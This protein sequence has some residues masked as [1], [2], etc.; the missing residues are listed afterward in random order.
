MEEALSAEDAAYRVT[1]DELL[2]TWA[3]W[4]R[5]VDIRARHVQSFS[6]DGALLFTVPEMALELSISAILR[7]VIAPT[8][9]EL[10]GA[11]L[12]LAHD[13]TGLLAVHVNEGSRGSSNFNFL[14]VIRGALENPRFDHPLSYLQSIRIQDGNF[15][16]YDPD[17]KPSWEGKK[18]N[19]IIEQSKKG[20]IAEL[21]LT[22]ELDEA[23]VELGVIA[24]FV[25]KT[26]LISTDFKF[27]PLTPKQ[28]ARVT[29]TLGAL[30]GIDLPLSGR[31]TVSTDL[32]LKVHET[33]FGLKGGPGTASLHGLFPGTPSL[34]ISNLQVQGVFNP[35]LKTLALEE[36]F[37][38]TDGTIISGNG[39][40]KGE[41]SDPTLEADITVEHLPVSRIATIWPQTFAENAR[42]WITSRVSDGKLE[43][44]DAHLNFDSSAWENGITDREMI[45]AQ[46]VVKGS[47]VDYLPGLPVAESVT[48]NGWYDGIDLH[49]N[50]NEG[51]IGN[52]N[53]QNVIVNIADINGPNENGIIRVKSLGPV[54]DLVRTFGSPAVRDAGIFQIDPDML[55]GSIETA[56]AIRFPLLSDLAVNDLEV[57]GTA[58][59]ENVVARG[60][61]PSPLLPKI[62]LKNL[63]GELIIDRNGFDLSGTADTID[64]HVKYSWHENFGHVK[65]NNMRRIDVLARL[66]EA[67]RRFLKID[68]DH[69]HGFAEADITL[70]TSADGVT[71]GTIFIDVT[72]ALLDLPFLRWNKAPG[73]PGKAEISLVLKDG[74]PVSDPTFAFNSGQFLAQGHIKLNNQNSLEALVLD[75]LEVGETRLSGRLNFEKDGAQE[76]YISAEHLDLRPYNGTARITQEN[77]VVI[78]GTAEKIILTDEIS[79]AEA[80]GQL[81][82]QSD[83]EITVKGRA[84]EL[85]LR[86]YF[87]HNDDSTDLPENREPKTPSTKLTG[88]IE[89][90]L[91]DDHIHLSNLRGNAR[92]D[93]VKI[94]VADIEI[95]TENSD[96]IELRI[97]DHDKGGRVLLLASEN[98]GSVLRALDLT[99]DVVGGTLHLQGT[100]IDDEHHNPLAG[101][102]TISDFH[103]IN[104]PPLAKLLTIATL[105]GALELLSG[106]GLP[107]D[108]M[109]A[110]FRYQNG[111][112]SLNKARATGLSLGL[113]INGE[114]NI[115]NDTI[116]LSGT[117]IPAYVLNS[118]VGHLPIIGDILTGGDGEGMFAATYRAQ[119]SLKDT[120]ISVNPLT[121]LAPGILRDLF[122]LFEPLQANPDEAN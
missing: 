103:V 54:D 97:T 36:V 43:R 4:E 25:K 99:D 118:I 112:L 107:F 24:V 92:Y 76:I 32:Q 33:T 21:E 45:Y 50:I 95:F 53:L 102:L 82:Q 91:I 5:Y 27:S 47:T 18:V 61:A 117:I 11:D 93:G 72:D 56:L 94:H 23:P 19:V 109:H 37:V 55:S 79:L 89:R 77:H 1:F 100:F 8:K 58:K 34:N 2:L 26:G 59:L 12:H 71:R 68:D 31:A 96:K 105:T 122:K 87:K 20:L 39:L 40:I 69:V 120:T 116:D 80:E 111:K 49:L 44:L 35:Q 29:S 85:D 78:S 115:D 46:F 121:A 101:D 13:A 17:L 14:D 113:T 28:L 63:R 73:N 42:R 52:Q 15:V 88:K 119:G 65:S 64:T 48:A 83:G 10:F 60:L 67:E 74:I 16:V 30:E 98:A 7:G 66:G 41:W 86:P 104:A 75:L 108:R 110:P 51:R 62:D 106:Q 9:L 57:S 22:V 3:G 84:R 38:E 114:I 6:T 90:V 81:T 70:T